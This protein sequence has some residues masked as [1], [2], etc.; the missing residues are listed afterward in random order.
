MDVFNF[1]N[2]LVDDYADYVRSFITIADERIRASVDASLENGR[3]WPQPL[4]QL[5]PAYASGGSLD[6]LVEEGT[7]LPKTRDVF[8]VGKSDDDPIGTPLVPH[9][10]QVEALRIAHEGHPYVVTTGTGSGKS[11]TYMIPIVDEILRTGSGKGTRAVVVYPMNALA[12]SQMGE[13]EKFLVHGVPDGPPVTF[14]RY[15]GQEGEEEKRK[16]IENP[17]DILLT[18]YVMLELILTRPQEHRLVDAAKNLRFLVLDELHTYRGRQGADVAMLV[19]RVRERLGASDLQCIGTSATMSSEGNHVDRQRRVA[20]VATRLFGV[21]VAP[22]HVVGETLQRVT[23]DLDLGD[24]ATSEALRRDVEAIDN[25]V[26]RPFEEVARSTL[27]SWVETTFG[28]AREPDTGRMIRAEPKRLEGPDGAAAHLAAAVGL[29][30]D[31]VRDA[32]RTLLLRASEIRDDAGR[33]LFAFRLHQFLSKGDA[34]YATLDDAATRHVTL[35]GQRFAPDR[36][37][38][39]ILLPLAFCRECGHEFYTTTRTIG[40]DG[41]PVHGPRDLNDRDTGEEA[42]A[43]FLYA[44]E[45]RPWPNDDETAIHHLPTDWV[46]VTKSGQPRVK[47]HRRSQR[48]TLVHVA[49]DGVERPG[50]RPFAWIPAP[51]R[52][53]PA[54][55]VA[56]PGR[57]SDYAK[58]NVFS[59]EG[60]S[61]STTILGLAALRQLRGSDLP[62]SARKLLSFTDNRQ[63]AA[64]QAG[65]F[66]DFI[67][68]GVLRGGLYRAVTDAGPDGLGHAEVAQRVF[69]VLALP[70]E[71]YALDPTLVLGGRR[72]TE[73]VLRE[74]LAYRLFHDLKRGWRIHLPN[75]E[76][77]G[78]VRIDYPDLDE[79]AHH[80]PLWSDAHPALAHATPEERAYV[81]HVLLDVLRKDLAIHADP[82]RPEYQERVAQRSRTRLREPWSIS[83]NERLTHAGVAIPRSRKDG[84][85]VKE[86]TFLSGNSAFGR[87]LRRDGVLRAW[88]DGTD[89]AS[90]ERLIVDLLE[91]LRRAGLVTV[92]TDV[93][94]PGE[95]PGYRLN[96]DAMRWRT[97]DGAPVEDPLLRIRPHDDGGKEPPG[98][99]ANPYFSAYYRDVANQLGGVRAAEHTAQVP[100]ETRLEREAEFREG[101]LHA[102]F[103]SPTMELGV[104]IASLNVVN[105]RNVPP[106]PANYAQRSGRAGRS[107]QPALVFSYASSLSPHDQYFFKRQEAMVAGVVDAPRIDLANEELV[108][109]HAHAIWLGETGIDLGRS[110]V[111]V[112]DITHDDVP[113]LSSVREKVD[114]GRA[115]SRAAER[116]RR[117]LA[118]LDAD[119]RAAAWWHDDWVDETLRAAP[120]RFDAAANR[121][122]AL[123]RAAIAQM[124]RQNRVIRDAS[125]TREKQRNAKRLRREAETQRDLLQDK[126][127]ASS[128]DFFSYRYYASEG[129]LPGYAF[130]R[131]PLSA[132]IPG[133]GRA[134]GRDDYLSRPRFLAIQEFGPRA[135]VYHDGAKYRVER[136]LLPPTEE[137]DAGVAETIAKR[138]VACGYLHP[139]DDR[140]DPEVCE[141]CGA[142]LEQALHNL[143]RMQNVTTRRVE[144]I[145]SDEEERQRQGYEVITG[146]R[147]AEERGETQR[148]TATLERDGTTLATLDYGQ[149][150]TLWRIN[151]GWRRRK[152]A[153]DIGFYLDVERGTWASKPNAQAAP[154]EFGGDEP[155]AQAGKKVV[156]FVEDRRNALVWT[157]G[158]PMSIEALAS[159]QAALK[160][161]IQLG[162]QLEDAELA[163]EALPTRS[164]R[165]S[166]LLYEAAEGGAGVLKSLVDDPAAVPRIARL[167][168]ELLHFDPDTG[169]DRGRAPG[170]RERCEAA[171]YDCLMAYG[172]QSDH[173]L[174]DR[175]LVRDALRELQDATLRS[176]PG[177][178]SRPEHLARLEAHCDTQLE[179]RFLR[180]LQDRLLRLPDTAQELVDLNGTIAKPDFTYH[181][182]GVLVFVDGKVHLHDDVAAR[183]RVVE[184][185]AA[186]AG[187][188]VLRI[189]EDGDWNELF[190]TYA[191]LFGRGA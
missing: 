136:V 171:C 151:L 169:E 168:L 22:D 25:L 130:P 64:L 50:G 42:E 59:S 77:V 28:V 124:D 161:A 84:R 88:E 24:G 14:A 105:L 150:A 179:R 133:S 121:W 8:R 92:A 99:D 82:L 126:G 184:D 139:V 73:A 125:A 152:D 186:D 79:V 54:C 156:P 91:A 71:A 13:L 63:D 72:E 6:T 32:V 98:A 19:R 173:A 55:G 96:A 183:D 43:G 112:L 23:P 182:Q 127:H 18:N 175:F 52:F 154:E 178:A 48:P 110:L 87:F 47:S 145:N 148:R 70:F 3:L 41:M 158:V 143:L 119:L 93:K 10:H 78:L 185:A 36:D 141:R 164:E 37:R 160:N 89:V 66:N 30:E 95:H 101:S 189:P 176:A 163:A 21:D 15:T 142:R 94:P 190:E 1:R 108:R 53:C 114:D 162:Y 80:E 187:W 117:T 58:L 51:F 2:V 39:A 131:L 107:G 155:E 76:Q 100:S 153:S 134:N 109:A 116:V 138:C 17:P 67:D 102:L 61:T 9:Q 172:N 16:I 191:W 46:E 83:D 5:N 103:C 57:R 45:D 31:R 49:P 26:T 29:D 65:H 137:G 4:V 113:L 180:A 104:D 177:S 68:V 20:E 11:L 166:L 123:Y 34:V 159:I 44:S 75:L 56:H 85:D 144:R 33:P 167:A 81:A 74:V 135:V 35:D 62:A 146:Y 147:F 40:E 132:F 174:L 106:T 149:A 188:D 170:A 120:R 38:E 86:S 27:A 129:F 140:L 165:A 60:R 90:T 122:R 69:D 181:S 128:S 111:D 115:L 7:L 118:T 157:P 97:G 12:N